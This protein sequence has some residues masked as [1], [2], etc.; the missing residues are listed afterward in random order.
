[1]VFVSISTFLSEILFTSGH[2]TWHVEILEV[3][4]FQF[5]MQGEDIIEHTDGKFHVFTF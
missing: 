1:M 5:S 3:I 4:S 2:S